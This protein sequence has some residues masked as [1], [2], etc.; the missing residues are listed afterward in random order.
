[1]QASAIIFAGGASRR[2]GQSKARQTV[3]G[4]PMLERVARAVGSICDETIVAGGLEGAE[5][6]PQFEAKWV[7]DP[8]DLTGPVAGLI[9]GLRS[10]RNDACLAV[11]CD[12]P[13]LN[14]VLLEHLL[15]AS[16][17]HDAAV[18]KI[19]SHV[20]A[21]HAAYTRSCL[22]RLEALIVSQSPSMQSILEGLDVYC[23]DEAACRSI[24]PTGLSWFNVNTSD[25]L[26][27]AREVASRGVYVQGSTCETGVK[28]R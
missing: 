6:W 13:F 27:L 26:E 24:D 17:G 23:V 14:P 25:D 7:Y 19:D 15:E 16:V 9:A 10:A 8:P 22:P 1:M 4:V 28:G 12:M 2:M 3:G 5:K 20:Q 11:A 21:L 18:P